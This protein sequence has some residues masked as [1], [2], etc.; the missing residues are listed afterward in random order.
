MAQT[1]SS[2]DVIVIRGARVH[3][4]KN[5]SLTIPRN[6]LVVFTGLSGSGKSSLAFD[7]LY[8]E[9]QRRYVESLSAY[10]RQFLGLMDKPDVDQ[11]E[12][13]SPAISI[14]QKSTSHNPRSTVGTVTEIYDY[15]RL[16]YA[17]IGIPHCP[18]CGRVVQRQTVE[19]IVDTI[20]AFPKKTK[21]MILAPVVR[22][23]KGEHKNML[24]EVRKAG[25]VRVRFDGA[26]MSIDEA[27][28]LNVDKQKKHRVEV[29]I[30][31]L[32]IGED[33]EIKEG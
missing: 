20:G 12:G 2:N 11:I 4:L 24:A 16:L 6:K 5:V 29:V 30:D 28:D 3:N 26:T 1:T 9:G 22:D 23:Q 18:K 27:E 21:I 19:Q 31:R 32:T 8:A 33:A 14:D 25:Y 15:L 17:R 13:L 10:A 7:T